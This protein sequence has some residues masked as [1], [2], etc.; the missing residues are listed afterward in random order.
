MK[1]F[2]KVRDIKRAAQGRLLALP[3]VHAVAVGSKI[4][5]GK[6]TDETSIVVLVVKKKPLSELSPGEVIPAE[7][8]G[9]K[10]DVYESEIVRTFGDDDAKY[11]PLRG[12]VLITPAGF[13]DGTPQV[14]GKGI[15]GYGTLGC[16]ARTKGPDAK[17]VAL[18]CHHIV[19]MIAVG[20]KNTLQ[21]ATSVAPPDVSFFGVNTP[22]TL[23][24][25]SLTSKSSDLTVVYQTSDTDTPK[26]IASEMAKRITS[27]GSPHFGAT[28]SSPGA[29]FEVTADSKLE[30]PTVAIFSAPV[31]NRTDVLIGVSDSKISLLRRALHDGA[32]YVT[33]LSNKDPDATHGAFVPFAKGKNSADIAGAIAKAIND[34]KLS[35]VS[36]SAAGT[37]VTVSGVQEIRCE[38]TSDLQVGQPTNTM[39]A[40]PC[41]SD[42]IGV[43]M[44]A[45]VELDVALIQLDAGLKYR[46]DILEIDHVNQTDVAGSIK[47]THDIHLES[48]GYPLKK[49]GF[50]TGITRGELELL[51]QD[52]IA[53]GQDSAH[54][55]P[56]W[57]LLKRWYKGA[58]RI[59]RGNSGSPVLADGGD[60][61]SAV[62]NDNDEVVGILFGGGSDHAVATPIFPI[63]TKFQ[64]TL[65]T[66]AQ[67]GIDKVVPSPAKAAAP[68]AFSAVEPLRAAS[69]VPLL[70][71]L[72]RVQREIMSTPQGQ[73]YSELA[74][75]HFG[76]VQTLVNTN[77]RVAA[78]WHRNGGPQ[79][80]QALLRIAQIPGQRIPSEIDGRPLAACLKKIQS[81]LTRYGSGALSSDLREFGPA[82][83]R[84]AGLSY[85]EVLTAFEDAPIPGNG[86]MGDSPPQDRVQRFPATSHYAE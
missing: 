25:V 20:Q 49:R 38:L 81:V 15:G 85:S 77:R 61:G 86:G 79:I 80:L 46:A 33:L 32:A 4:V 26:S 76:E 28:P 31:R 56:D 39:C 30:E 40:A 21:A 60:S 24:V 47:D 13:V 45:S 2:E 54:T 62:L 18:T 8:D 19:G 9:V 11:R 53:I 44:D 34:M 29:S 83:S 74:E 66:A 7:I 69:P 78:V 52:G 16:F 73:R 17:I 58:F 36:A 57:Q 64:L 42:R 48:K 71:N 41:T 35:Q 63:L 10:T 23:V 51:D 82:L 5:G 59:I 43:V 37:S 68:H 1:D 55:P 65:E 84:L 75:R 27:L 67:P 3:G 14:P 6:P 22:G 70:E 50:K 12:G 72:Q